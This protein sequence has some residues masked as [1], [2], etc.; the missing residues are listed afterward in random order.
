[1]EPWSRDDFLVLPTGPGGA[2]ALLH[3]ATQEVVELPLSP[4]AVPQV[5]ISDDGLVVA[6][7]GD[8]T[9]RVSP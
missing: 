5:E 3:K 2:Y 6:V 8:P 1:M 7:P 9:Y 4:S